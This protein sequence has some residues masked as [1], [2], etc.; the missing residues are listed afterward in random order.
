[1][2][3]VLNITKVNEKFYCF[4]LVLFSI[5]YQQNTNLF[6][7]WCNQLWY[8]SD[9]HYDIYLLKRRQLITIKVLVTIIGAQWEGM[10]DVGSARYEPMHD[11][12]GFKLQ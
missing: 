11:R 3:S 7:A 5:V 6:I 10:G 12:K 2:V 9:L 8:I 4:L 1:M